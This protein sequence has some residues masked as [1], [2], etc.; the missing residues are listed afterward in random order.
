MNMKTSEQIRYNMQQVKC[1]DSEIELIL[2]AEL[3]K[4]GIRYRKNVGKIFGKPDLAFI[5]IK[6]AVFCDSEFWHGYNWEE[7]R[8]DFKSNQEFWIPKIE[9]NIQR[10]IEVTEKL[11]AEGWI[12]LRFWGRDIQKN[13]SKC[14]D[15]IEEAVSFRKNHTKQDR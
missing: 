5:G 12:V 11:K 2:R 14:A 13:V 7:R 10:D 1:K 3:R 4:R 8:K 9:R 6:V 15:I